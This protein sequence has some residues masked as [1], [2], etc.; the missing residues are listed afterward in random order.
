V[1][2]L[3]VADL[4]VHCSHRAVL[5][6][7]SRDTPVP[8]FAVDSHSSHV[9]NL[10]PH[11]P[12]AQPS[13]IKTPPAPFTAQTRMLGLLCHKTLVEFPALSYSA[14]EKKKRKKQNKK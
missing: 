12:K 4:S 10:C 1:L 7:P 9:D 6:L 14:M 11:S 5:P 8:P 2:I 3:T 13:L